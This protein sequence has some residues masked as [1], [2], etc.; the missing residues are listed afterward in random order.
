MSTWH[1]EYVRTDDLNEKYLLLRAAAADLRGRGGPQ[2]FFEVEG[3]ADSLR[4]LDEQIEGQLIAF[5]ANDFGFPGAYRPDGVDIGVQNAVREA[6]L[7]R[8][9]DD[10]NADLADIRRQ[11]LEEHPGIHKA[12]I[13]E[14]VDGTVRYHLPE[15]S[16]ETTNF[17]TVREMVGLVDYTT[18]SAQCDH[19][20]RTY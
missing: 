19:L 20:S 9:Y 17:L 6:I 16:N 13:V 3:V 2:E 8:K 1:D 11:L 18:N 7:E 10:T 15:G 4:R 12:V 14:H 5:V